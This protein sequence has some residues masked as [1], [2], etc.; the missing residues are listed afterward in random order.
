[1]PQVIVPMWLD[2][3][4]FARLAEEV[5]VGVYATRGTA[6]EWTV[7]GL[8]KSFLRAVNGGEDC[9]RMREKA[10]KLG[11]IAR[12]EPGRMVATRELVRY[13]NLGCG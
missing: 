13:A 6:P 5:G 9:L 3:Y 2:L 1:V 10:K 7:D 8:S 11:D 4:N 12:K